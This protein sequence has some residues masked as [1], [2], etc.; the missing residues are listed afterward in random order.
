MNQKKAN[1]I[2]DDNGNT[3]SMRVMSLIALPFAI[4]FGCVTLFDPNV[5]KE[6]GTNLTVSF[7]AAAFTPKA[8]QK[9]A[10]KILK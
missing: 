10:E 3:S 8:V 9:F 6:A 7:L 1:L 4:I 2:Q 5:D